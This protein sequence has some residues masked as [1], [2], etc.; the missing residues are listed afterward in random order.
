[1]A[2]RE[3]ADERLMLE[4]LA[5]ALAANVVMMSYSFAECFIQTEMQGE[6]QT[7]EMALLPESAAALLDS[8]ISQRKNA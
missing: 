6:V 8:A 5:N 3:F 7:E 4:R 1:V 2:A